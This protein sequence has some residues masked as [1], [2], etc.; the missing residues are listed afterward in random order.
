MRGFSMLDAMVRCRV[1][2]MTAQVLK[3]K[4]SNSV[5]Q[6]NHKATIVNVSI[7]CLQ[8]WQW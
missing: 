2:R 8:L 1:T 5:T 4:M 7:D 6:Q 3:N